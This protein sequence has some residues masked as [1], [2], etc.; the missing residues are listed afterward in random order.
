MSARIA[1]VE[2]AHQEAA[3]NVEKTEADAAAMRS[4]LDVADAEHRRVAA[5]LDYT[6]LRAPFDGVVVERNVHPGHLVQ[7]GGGG[8]VAP[9]L[10]VMSIDP[11]RV[12]VDV[13]EIDAVRIDKGT[14]AEIRIPS[15]PGDPLTSAVTRTSW[16][17][18][19]TSRTLTA[20]I[21]VPN[22]EGR[23]RPGQYVQVKLNVAELT[24]V[25]S[26][27]KTAIVTQD[28]Q[29]YCFCVGDDGKVRRMAIALGLQAG[30]DFEIR[31]GLTGDENVIGVNASSFREGQAVELA[32]P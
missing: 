32:K 18:N 9:L 24:D 3:A 19:A 8:G 21:D 17:L 22:P 2:A 16:S 5:L 13:P 23:W 4:R 25:L 27:P 7:A 15:M 6:T 14:V 31:S 29:T 20:E 28:K 26:L 1:S 11:V 10:T 30:N 12:F